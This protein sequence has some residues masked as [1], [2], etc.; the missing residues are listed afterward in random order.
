MHYTVPF[1]ILISIHCFEPRHN[2]LLIIS[3]IGGVKEILY[4]VIIPRKDPYCWTR[5]TV[6]KF[7][8]RHRKRPYLCP[9]IQYVIWRGSAE[10][11][12]IIL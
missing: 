8:L 2:Q 4:F 5:D 6:G 3:I 12:L 11:Y 1:K 10:I 7:Y 9:Q